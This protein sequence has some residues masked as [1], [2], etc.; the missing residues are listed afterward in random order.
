MKSM[1][2][3]FKI[4]FALALIVFVAAVFIT[5]FNAFNPSTRD[6]GGLLVTNTP[7]PT[8]SSVEDYILNLYLQQHA[9]D[10]DV[11]PSADTTPVVF[12]ILPGELPV[13]VAT[14]LQSQGLIR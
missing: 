5:I 10:L 6:S 4:I 1:V 9:N 8:P 3:F 12:S 13:D 2:R 11:P 7:F 14:R